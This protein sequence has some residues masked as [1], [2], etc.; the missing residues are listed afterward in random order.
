MVTT[1]DRAKVGQTTY[2]AGGDR[3]DEETSD[4]VDVPG[5]SG[6]YKTLPAAK[7]VA[8]SWL[9]KGAMHVYITRGTY[10][11]TDIPDDEYGVV[12]HAD[13]VQDEHWGCNGWADGDGG[14]EWVEESW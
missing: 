10:E 4:V 1:R 6:E 8:R 14:I 11:A 3:W 9:R 7:L 12:H 13:R 5:C 2:I